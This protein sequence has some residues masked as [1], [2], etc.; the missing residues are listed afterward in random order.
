MEHQE[1]ILRLAE[2]KTR[3]GLGRSAIYMR[4]SAGTFPKPVALSM[5]RDGRPALVGFPESEINEWIRQTI[6]VSR[7]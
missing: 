3:T 4:I 2:V 7:G 5:R 1:R 6:A